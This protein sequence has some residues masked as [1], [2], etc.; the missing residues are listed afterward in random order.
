MT[1]LKVM[2]LCLPYFTNDSI[3]YDF[4]F[5]KKE[6]NQKIVYNFAMYFDLKINNN[7]FMRIIK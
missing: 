4:L 3:F 6:L 5:F 2:V 7:W 1:K